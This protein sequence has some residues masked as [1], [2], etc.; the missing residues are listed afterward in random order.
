MII[1]VG[2]NGQS[3]TFDKMLEL[4]SEGYRTRRD[5]VA[6]TCINDN[7]EIIPPQLIHHILAKWWGQGLLKKK[8]GEL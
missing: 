3:E 8:S 2:I 6:D 7:G 5:I 4:L 1:T